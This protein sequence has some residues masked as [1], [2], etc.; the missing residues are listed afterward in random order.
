LCF[1]FLFLC[2]FH[3]FIIFPSPLAGKIFF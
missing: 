2:F 1:W 3:L